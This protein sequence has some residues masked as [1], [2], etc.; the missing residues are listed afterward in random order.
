[1][2]GIDGVSSNRYQRTAYEVIKEHLAARLKQPA[3]PIEV[4]SQGEPLSIQR[5]NHDPYWVDY[6]PH[7][8]CCTWQ[9]WITSASAHRNPYL[10]HV[11]PQGGSHRVNHLG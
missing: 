6:S 7:F 8:H 3:K 9:D 10:P 5:M 1:M 11:R 4:L 2:T